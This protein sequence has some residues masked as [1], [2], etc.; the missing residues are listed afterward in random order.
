MRGPNL[1]SV[2]LRLGGSCELAC[3]VCDCRAAPTTA[4][5]QTLAD[6][7]ARLVL[8]GAPGVDER[9]LEVVREARARGFTD[10]VARTSGLAWM[11]PER[12]AALAATGVHAAL[13]PLFSAV[14]GV[15]DRIAGRPD[16]L[17]HALVGLRALS[18]AGLAVE[19]EIPLLSPKIQDASGV[20]ALAH[21][22]VPALRAVRFFVPPQRL[23]PAL[24]PPAWAEGAPALAAALRKCRE[25]GVEATL[26]P[27][28]GVP[29]CVLREA[30]DL[31]DAYRF[32]PR[33]K[34]ALPPGSTHGAACATCAVRAQCPGITTS[35]RAARGEQGL[36]PYA[37]K[38]KELYAQRSAG[39]PVFTV[40]HRRAASRVG[41]I[42]LRPTVNCNQD[43]PF[44]SANETSKNVW[45]DAASML[46][47][48]SRAARRGVP[49]VSFSG[50]E[51]TLS[52]DLVHYVDAARRLGIRE[53]EL[54]TNGV[55][56][57]DPA[58]VK[59]LRDAGL[60][61]AFVS[62][63]AH[64]ERLSQVMT[65]KLDDHARTL[66]AVRNLREA[67]VACVVNH[68]I[69]TRNHPY[70][71]RFVELVH[72][73][74]GAVCI[75]FAFVTPQ[76]KALEEMSLLP[77]ISEVALSLR[78][79][80]HRA[81]ELGQPVVIGSRQ[82]IPPCFLGE[83]AAWSDVL[84]LAAEAAAEDAP[85]KQRAPACDTCKYTRQCAGLWRPYVAVHGLGEIS[86]VQGEPL[87]DEDV[88]EIQAR[89]HPSVWREPGTFEA[90]HPRLRERE[91]ETE[92]LAWYRSEAAPEPPLRMLP[93]LNS[94]RSRPLRVALIGSGRQARR[95]EAA[96][97][98]VTGISIDAVA[99]PGAP[100]LDPR[101][102]GGCPTFAS[103]EE[104]V[105]AI[106]PEALIIAAATRAHHALA[107]VA[108][109]RGI[110]AL[111]EKPLTRGEDEAEDL[112]RAAAARPDVVLLPAHT[113]LFAAGVGALLD[114]S[115]LPVLAFTRRCTPSSPE[116]MRAWS[117]TALHEVLYHALALVGRAAGGGVP[118]VLDARHR[119]DATPEQIGLTLLYPGAQVEILL[120]LV[121]TVDEATLTRRRSAADPP[122][123]TWRRAGPST[124]VRVGETEVPVPR[125][126]SDLER[127][128][129]HFR[130]VVLG[131]ARPMVALADGLDVMR[132]ARVAIEALDAAGAPFDRPGAPRHV[133][134]AALAP[135]P[136]FSGAR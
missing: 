19:I 120:D 113:L 101:E 122:A 83:F 33:A 132:A 52:R 21:R 3:A 55:L 105:D 121:A 94:Q 77:R 30:P 22:A 59:A 60:T 134:S 115:E 123:M 96:A 126:G 131:K 58:R 73:Q 45:T 1:R 104:A 14:P 129:A 119:G 31:Q 100:Q 13:V 18:A 127:M 78:R 125:D 124:S 7:G 72:G 66:Q 99:S 28:D 98:G 16:A 79:A 53:I 46:R 103:L 57:D 56:L 111:L 39:S 44:C 62:L 80:M 26:R 135:F 102:F 36:V 90:L 35:Y 15:H 87:T 116:G 8:R 117:R 34:L 110:P 97:R 2:E 74:L 69:T 92:G 10:I 81:L 106:R 85:Q 5:L 107:R 67:G 42:V 130:D 136:R 109:A 61:H 24:S 95:L 49:R 88:T 65:R 20:V 41:M 93:V 118:R 91:R 86:P 37:R 27:N 50:G 133:A 64:H 114:A 54:V 25:L 82:G 38:P 75:S 9:F 63:H 47:A 108:L 68:V 51:P 17:A 84:M 89:V 112:V 71:T 23:P 6:G 32:D 76:Y 70:L 43:C 48:I 4:P 11:L 128:L 12:A 29:L 40:E